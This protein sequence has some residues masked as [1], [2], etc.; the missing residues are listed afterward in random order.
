M[1]DSVE[2]SK[3]R[4]QARVRFDS[5]EAEMNNRDHVSSS[6]RIHRQASKVFLPRLI[7]RDYPYHQSSNRVQVFNQ[8][9]D[10]IFRL[11]IK[12]WFHVIL[13]MKSYVS[14]PIFVAIWYGMIWVFALVFTMVDSS[15][16][17]RDKDCGLAEPGIP[18]TLSAAYAFSLETCTTVGYGLPGSANGFFNS[19]CEGLQIAITFQMM[20][21]MFSN[22]F[23][24]SFLFALMS[25]SET[26][27]IQIIFSKKLCVNVV[28][29]KVCI[30]VRCYDLV[31]V[32]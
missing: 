26:R 9:R 14:F 6:Q 10:Q 27:S 15:N 32:L 11:A 29:D 20:W 23:L 18:I 25:K 3:I 17:N 30:N 19:D 1:A 28:D 12:D 7:P 5:L 4:A 24:V 2:D 16:F 21:S 13:R 31:R 22:A 8:H